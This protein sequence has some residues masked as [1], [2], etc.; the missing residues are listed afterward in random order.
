[1]SEDTRPAGTYAVITKSDSADCGKVNGAYPRSLYVGVSGDVVAVAI[2]GATVTFKAVP[3]GV[4]PI[5]FK[6][7]NS[8]STTATDM[9][10][11]Y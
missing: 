8:T 11:L 6:R 5:Q 7:I 3:V 1:M 9:V 2:N 4:L 10:A